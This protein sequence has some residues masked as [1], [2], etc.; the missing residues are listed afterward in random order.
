MNPLPGG[1]MGIKPKQFL[2]ERDGAVIT[3][4]FYNAPQNLLNPETFME[5][6]QLR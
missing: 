1:K 5:L 3:W 6:F 2:I 4:L